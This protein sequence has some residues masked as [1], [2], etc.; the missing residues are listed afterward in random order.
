MNPYLSGLEAWLN[1]SGYAG[2]FVA[3]LLG[4]VGIPAV[5]SAGTV[6]MLRFLVS[7]EWW[8][9]ALVAAAGETTGQFLLYSAGRFGAEALIS[10]LTRNA[11][12]RSRDCN[13]F[14]QFYSRYGGAAV[15]LCRF[16]PGVKSLSGLP[17]GIARMSITRFV[18]YTALG[19]LISCFAIAAAV[20]IIGQC[21]PLFVG[22][23][24]QHAPLLLIVLTVGILF[25]VLLR[26][27]VRACRRDRA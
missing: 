8:I 11:T 12:A 18:V 7:P 1:R 20:H 22:Y 17:A 9:A 2:V 4:N 21:S 19:A 26:R 23:T 24:R 15:L 16:I 27:I 10:P 3:M 14:E 25:S 13:R 6:L 5:G